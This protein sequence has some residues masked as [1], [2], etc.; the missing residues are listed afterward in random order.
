MN[1][2]SKSLRFVLKPPPLQLALE[3]A[4]QSL[5]LLQNP[6]LPST[7]RPLLPL[8]PGKRIAVIGPHWNATAQVISIVRWSYW[9]LCGVTGGHCHVSS[10]QR[11]SN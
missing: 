3:A 1:S 7:G 10:P 6:P 9:T 2:S 5:V 11:P 8:P 4:Q